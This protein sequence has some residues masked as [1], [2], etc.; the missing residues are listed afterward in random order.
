MKR[1]SL[2][3]NSWHQRGAALLLAG[4]LLAGVPAQ[5]AQVRVNT[6]L[7]PPPPAEPPALDIRDNAIQ[8]SIDRAIEIALQRNLGI[9]IQ[10]YTRVQQRLAIIE[11]LGLYDLNATIDAMADNNNQPAATR[12]QASQTESQ[13]VNFGLRQRTPQGGLVSVGWQ[14]SRTKSDIGTSPVFYSSGMTFS[15]D[16]P[17]LRNYGR[18]ANERSILVAQI[19]SQLSRQD[20]SL[21]VTTI[22]Q[23]VINAYWALVNAREQL[24]VAQESLQLARDLHDRNKIQVEV[25]TLAPLEL[26]QSE[27]AIAT[28]EEGIIQATSAV[29]DAEDVLRQLLNLP[30]GPLW[31]TAIVPTSD[32]K[33]EQRLTVNVDE[34][35][36]IA[37]AQRPELV[38]QQIQLDQAKRDAEYFRTQLKPSL[39]L[40]VS[41]GYSGLGT[42]Y[43]GAFNQ[44]TG[45]DFRGWSAQL[46]FAYPI[47]NRAARAQS[48]SANVAVDRFQ[49]LYDQE[50]LVI[51]TEVRR[52]ARALDTAVK[53]ID[54]AMKARQFQEKN[55]DAQ[56][57]RYENGMSTSFEITQI[58]EQL[59]AARSSEV[60]AIV[61]YRTALAEY[62]RAT[63]KLLDQE[64]VVI[65]DPQEGDAIA[66]R[67]DFNRAPLPGERR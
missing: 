38:S 50:R 6:S 41:Y 37:L 1:T 39:D 35:L 33:T 51:E 18:Y 13:G 67:F 65:D 48:A 56:K 10:R 3:S 14:N 60:T 19:N 4:L 58:Q 64:G 21:Q 8:L 5:G 49:S 55:L 2:R 30:R 45:L 29:G 11:A 28:R 7:Q 61:N 40:A 32:P 53:S 25:G 44:I 57:K 26:T 24:V 31:S 20:F 27:A 16:Q 66:K 22:T 15:F 54:A 34:A 12:F 63:G 62:Y 46:N 36:R 52:A 42:A 43:S 47:Q 59:T 9:V 17:L 23:Q